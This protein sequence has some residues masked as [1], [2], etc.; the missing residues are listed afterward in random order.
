MSNNGMEISE[1]DNG[2]L[3]VSAQKLASMLQ[4]SRRTL[5]R[6]VSAGKILQPVRVGRAVRWRLEE[7]KRWIGRGCPSLADW[8]KES[9]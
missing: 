7:V 9:K 8:E 3:L 1:R 2:V 5:S 6:L 4:I